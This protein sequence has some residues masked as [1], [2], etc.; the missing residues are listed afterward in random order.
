[1]GCGNIS[2]LDNE[3]QNNLL[4]NN[5][6]EEKNNN[7][8]NDNND[9]IDI[10]NKDNKIE[11]EKEKEKNIKIEKSIKN[12]TKKNKVLTQKEKLVLE[13]K[14]QERNKM[15]EKMRKEMKEYQKLIKRKRRFLNKNGEYEESEDS[16]SRLQYAKGK[17]LGKKRKKLTPEEIE[18]GIMQDKKEEDKRKGRKAYFSPMQNELPFKHKQSEGPYDRNTSKS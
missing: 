4:S 16:D 15:K 2:T 8:N 13:K 17:N 1:M 5:N 18:D 6:N 11:K 14:K 3:K 7:D 12:E 10:K 9:L